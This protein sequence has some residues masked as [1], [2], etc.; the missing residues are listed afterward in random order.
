MYLLEDVCHCG[1]GQ[2]DPPLNHLGA[3]FLLSAVASCPA[4]HMDG[5]HLSGRPA[6]KERETRQTREKWSQDNILI[7]LKCLMANAL[8]KRWGKPIPANSSLEPG[9]NCR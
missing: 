8:I 3:S 9:T 1:E 5:V 7:K 2:C 6:L 4:V